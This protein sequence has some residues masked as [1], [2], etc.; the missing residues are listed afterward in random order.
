MET[1]FI[2]LT[3]SF[4]MIWIVAFSIS[5]GSLLWFQIVHL[6]QNVNFRL[7]EIGGQI[8]MQIQRILFF[9]HLS[10]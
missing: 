5:M 3:V 7:D 2:Y 1:I 10:R 6:I 8:S 4:M 9:L